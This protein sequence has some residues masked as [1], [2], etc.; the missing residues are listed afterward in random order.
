MPMSSDSNEIQHDFAF[1]D[2]IKNLQ[3]WAQT[4]VLSPE[5]DAT[6]CKALTIASQMIAEDPVSRPTMYEVTLFL[7]ETEMAQAFFCTP[8]CMDSAKC[9]AHAAREQRT[10]DVHATGTNPGVQPEAGGSNY[11]EPIDQMSQEEVFANGSSSTRGEAMSDRTVS[12]RSPN[13][14]RL[15]ARRVST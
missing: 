4:Q 5:C 11:T 15:P 7:L 10:F 9:A 13:L 6:L 1:A 3:D 12:R 2:Y 8:E 14:P